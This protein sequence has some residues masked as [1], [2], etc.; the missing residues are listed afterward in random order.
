MHFTDSDHSARQLLQVLLLEMGLSADLAELDR[1]VA[2]DPAFL[3]EL[4]R[5]ALTYL[6]APSS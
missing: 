3:Q 2:A 5:R 1:R 6:S 4:K